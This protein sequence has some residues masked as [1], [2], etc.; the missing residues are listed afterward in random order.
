MMV[1]ND[2]LVPFP[3]NLTSGWR[4]CD[5]TDKCPCSIQ[6]TYFACLLEAR[7]DFWNPS[8]E[9]DLGQQRHRSFPISKRARTIKQR[10]VRWFF[11]F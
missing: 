1:I 6:I 5:N 3:E 8:I 4:F 2:K 9:P 7:I 10:Y 11:T